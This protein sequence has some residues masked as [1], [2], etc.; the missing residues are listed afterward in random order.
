MPNLQA[1]ERNPIRRA[2]IATAPIAASRPYPPTAPASSLS[3]ARIDSLL[4]A[5]A[6]AANNAWLYLRNSHMIKEMTRL[7]NTMVVIGK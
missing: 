5:A 1:L 2:I 4:T 6:L 7:I 3:R